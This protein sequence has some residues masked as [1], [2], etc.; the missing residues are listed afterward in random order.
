MDAAT[1]CAEFRSYTPA[2]S[3]TGMK[4]VP[5]MEDH[6]IRYGLAGNPETKAKVR[7]RY[8]SDTLRIGDA[9]IRNQTFGIALSSP[10][11]Y[12]GIFGLAP[13]TSTGF[14]LDSAYSFVL[15]GFVEQGV[16]RSRAFAL[17]LRHSETP[18][19]ALILGGLDKGKF[20]GPL[21]RM[22]IVN[23]TDGSFR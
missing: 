11:S 3:S 21:I 20:I 6:E 15:N 13:D 1:M 10:G 4:P 17:D 14:T 22:P 9:V 12:V 8:H 16:I 2:F 23:G 7:I 5:A 18:N 19:G